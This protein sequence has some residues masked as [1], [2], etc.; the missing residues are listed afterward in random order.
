MFNLVLH[1]SLWI[2]TC[3]SLRYPG[4]SLWSRQNILDPSSD[5]LQERRTF[6][7]CPVCADLLL[8]DSQ[9]GKPT[10]RGN[11]LLRAWNTQLC[12]AGRPAQPSNV[13]F[14][15]LHKLQPAGG[16]SKEITPAHRDKSV[17]TNREEFLLVPPP[18]FDLVRLNPF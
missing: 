12:D 5:E 16:R 1:Q 4:V 18:T 17:F 8:L 15:P 10:D 13:S 11:V 3:S 6:R 7:S 14:L 9:G 2:L